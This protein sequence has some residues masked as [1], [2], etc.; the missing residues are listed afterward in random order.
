MDMTHSDGP[1]RMTWN[2]ANS[3]KPMWRVDIE[4]HEERKSLQIQRGR[5]VMSVA[6]K[7]NF[8]FTSIDE[9]LLG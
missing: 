2:L 5:R 3:G 4:H 1:F 8:P 9:S 6:W 7:V